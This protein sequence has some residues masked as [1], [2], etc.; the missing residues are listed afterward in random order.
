M[1]PRTKADIVYLALHS[2]I[3]EQALAPGAKLPEDV[4]GAHFGVSR[5]IV[6][7][8]F[9]RLSAEGLVEVRPKRTATV[10]RPS[11]EDAKEI[12]DLRRCLEREAVRQAIARW[13]PEFG[14]A[15]EG[16]VREEQ[17]AAEAGIASV[18]I[19]LAG[20]FHTRLAELTGNRLLQRYLAEVVSRCSL[21]LALYGRPHSSECAITEHREIIAALR[22]GDAGR[23]TALMDHHIGAVERRALI[24][25]VA[26]PDAGLDAV[27]SRYAALH[28]AGDSRTVV[29]LAARSRKPRRAS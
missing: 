12:F 2:A 9:G 25:D 28:S 17:A 24:A 3:I 8:A 19:R 15:L 14:S 22:D 29:D 6:R 18:S 13:K 7:S 16:H 27:L 23:A 5:T 1:T 10:A 11:L 26:D 20:A 4:I 21:I